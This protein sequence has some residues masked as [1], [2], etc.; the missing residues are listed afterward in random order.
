MRGARYGGGAV[1]VKNGTRT[2]D[3]YL[4]LDGVRVNV[5]SGIYTITIKLKD[6]GDIIDPQI[7]YIDKDGG[8][9]VFKT[10]YVC[11]DDGKAYAIR[12]TTKH[13]SDFYLPTE[14]TIDLTWLIILLSV[15]LFAEIVA[16]I[17]LLAK[18][19]SR[20]EEE[21]DTDAND[22]GQGGAEP[23]NDKATDSPL[24]DRT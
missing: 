18:R 13:L 15:I 10:E 7:V 24:S 20:N 2:F 22:D 3:V 11:D 5:E 17:I 9:E 23:E 8:V 19:R 1:Y 6:L 16:I 14:P 12:F 21:Q 4:E